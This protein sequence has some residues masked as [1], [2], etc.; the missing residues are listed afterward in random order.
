MGQ[1]ALM[2]EI[3]KYEKLGKLLLSWTSII[4]TLS[5]T[6]TSLIHTP[7]NTDIS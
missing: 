5:N 3:D 4:Q 1:Q 6:V 2:K 7:P